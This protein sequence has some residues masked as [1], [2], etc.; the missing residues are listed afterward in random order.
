MV[1]FD[2]YPEGKKKALT[3]SY[4]D[5]KVYDRKLVE[6]FNKYGI[7]GAFHVNAS[8]YINEPAD[9]KLSEIAELYKNHEISCHTFSH[10]FPNTLPK[11]TLIYE[12]L[13]DREILEGAS[14][15]PIRGMS[16]PYGQ[17][18]DYV[19]KQFKALGIEYS[20]TVRSTHKFGIPDDFMQWHPTCHHYE[21]LSEKLAMFKKAA[22]G[23]ITPLMLFYVWGHSIEFER[24]NNWNIIENF[25]K[26]ASTLDDVWFA[27]NI[28]I[29]DY[30]TALRNLK[31]N[32]KQNAVYNPSAITCWFSSD[33]K[34]V[35][36]A[37]GK[38]T[39]F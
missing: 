22:G 12:I 6:I 36:A 34:T 15:Y 24:N 2:L 27:T 37:P 23:G 21:N 1:V 5:G 16:Y 17:Y 7:K 38:T 31:F 32:V 4:D 28:E 11:E 14:G 19:I 39:A 29:Y 9:I 26:E 30:I 18:N 35:K 13:N 20:R 25:C 33:G 8:R 10:P 3:M